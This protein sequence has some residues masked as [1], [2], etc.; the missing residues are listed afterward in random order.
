M[1][2]DLFERDSTNQRAAASQNVAT[3]TEKGSSKVINQNGVAYLN[4]NLPRE[5]FQYLSYTIVQ[6]LFHEF[7]H[8]LN[9]ALSNTKY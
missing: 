2:L 6:N 4:M 8:A 1:I 7:G 9:S 5:D 3:L